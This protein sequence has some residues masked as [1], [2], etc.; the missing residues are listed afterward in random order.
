MVSYTKH[1][2]DLPTIYKMIDEYQTGVLTQKQLCEKY[3][4]PVA[5]FSYYYNYGKRTKD[6]KKGGRKHIDP[7]VFSEQIISNPPKPIPKPATKSEP[8]LIPKSISKP[9]PV[10]LPALPKYNIPTNLPTKL[11]SKGRKIVDLSKFL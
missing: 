10:T 11:D 1:N 3:H 5:T 6:L 9:P 7:N 4:V 8:K 2:T